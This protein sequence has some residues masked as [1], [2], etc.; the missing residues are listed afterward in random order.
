MMTCASYKE[1]VDRLD[2]IVN[3][4]KNV[5]CDWIVRAGNGPW[6]GIKTRSES[7]IM[8]KRGGKAETGRTKVPRTQDYDYDYD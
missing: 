7:K 2:G 4:L 8:I 5:G 3:A 1:M 6:D